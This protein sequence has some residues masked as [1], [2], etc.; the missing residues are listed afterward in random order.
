VRS[1]LEAVRSM[2]G[3]GVI[4]LKTVAE[5][6]SHQ[7]PG[8]EAKEPKTGETDQGEERQPSQ[9]Q[10]EANAG[11]D[12]DSEVDGHWE[13]DMGCHLPPGAEDGKGIDRVRGYRK[14]KQGRA[15]RERTDG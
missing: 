7:Q 3:L 6:A 5:A 11:I 10:M 15:K 9:R 8:V 2:D 14:N 1:T 12:K 4:A 13:D